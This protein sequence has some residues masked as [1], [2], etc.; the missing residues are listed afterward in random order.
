MNQHF[1]PRVYLKRFAEKRNGAYYV[2][3][4]D[5]QTKKVFNTNITNICAEKD[6][7]TLDDD[8]TTYADKLTIEKVYSDGF[9]PMYERIFG[10]LTNDTIFDITDQQRFEILLAI[11]QMYMR[12]PRIMR[13]SIAHHKAVIRGLVYDAKKNDQKGIS[14]LEEDFS[15][16]EWS[17]QQIID[18]FTEKVTKEFKEGHVYGI[19][20]LGVFHK[21]SKLEVSKSKVPSA[22]FTSDNPLVLQDLVEKEN[23]HPLQKTKEFVITLSDEYSLKIYHDNQFNLNTILRPIIPNGNSASINNTIFNQA[24]R[25]IIGK[26]ETF[27]SYFKV[28]EILEDTTFEGKVDMIRQ[29]LERFL[30]G[31]QNEPMTKLMKYY[32]DLFDQNGKLTF[33]EEQT[34]YREHQVLTIAWKKSRI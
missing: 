20:E 34:Y 1:V 3:V 28:V 30:D 5:K 15:F 13:L 23:S 26:K 33:E 11:F 10:I 17:E 25:F 14:Y 16:R 6:I 12:N 2:D 19:S 22:F 24:S 8:S 18:H 4:Y 32:L 31:K 27:E 29:F 9:E 7:Y 21:F